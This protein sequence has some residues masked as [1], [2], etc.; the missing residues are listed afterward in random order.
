MPGGEKREGEGSTPKLNPVEKKDTNAQPR[1]CHV[2][3]T[4]CRGG[5]EK[6]ALNLAY[7]GET[8]NHKDEKKK[9][10]FC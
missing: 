10:S 5:E 2:R 6:A 8:S 4:R 1:I 3:N 9:A 7:A